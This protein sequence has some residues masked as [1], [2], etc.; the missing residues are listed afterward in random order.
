[1]IGPI[2]LSK[3]NGAPGIFSVPL[4]IFCACKYSSSLTT[5]TILDDDVVRMCS[6]DLI[7]C[8]NRGK[9]GVILGHVFPREPVSD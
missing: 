6:S 2:D 7:G 4:A 1:M 3:I 9:K 8:D 5:I